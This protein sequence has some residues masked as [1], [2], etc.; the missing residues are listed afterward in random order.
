MA[1]CRQASSHY[2]SQCWL[3]LLSPYGVD[4]PQWV[5]N[6]QWNCWSLKRSWSITCRCCSNY[7]FILYLTPA[8]NRLHKDNCKTRWETFK[9]QALVLLILEA[10]QYK[11]SEF[12]QKWMSSSCEFHATDS[13]YMCIY[14]NSFR[15]KQNGWHDADG[16][17]RCILCYEKNFIMIKIVDHSDVVGES[18]VGAA[19]TT[20]SF[21][22]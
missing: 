7:I 9:F 15:H 19:P 3:S 20:S 2:L 10:W 21:S 8:F 1:W 11:C 22:T 4:R 18:P 14:S 12:R 16:A 13:M 5:N 17:F 6:K